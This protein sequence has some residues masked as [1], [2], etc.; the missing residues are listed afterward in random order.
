MFR[1]C[2]SVFIFLFFL[3][4]MRG[5]FWLD[6]TIYLVFQVDL[7]CYCEILFTEGFLVFSFSTAERFDRVIFELDH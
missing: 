5:C 4:D 2:F 7:G 6:L 1:E 3:W